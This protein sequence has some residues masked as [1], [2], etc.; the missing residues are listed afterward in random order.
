[1]THPTWRRSGELAA[2]DSVPLVPRG[3]TRDVQEAESL[4]LQG[5]PR[6]QQLPFPIHGHRGRQNCSVASSRELPS[7]LYVHVA[8]PDVA[9]VLANRDSTLPGSPANHR[10]CVAKGGVGPGVES[11]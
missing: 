2:R 3:L 5:R 4:R 10:G 1:M 9:V 8:L 6:G 7:I 11:P